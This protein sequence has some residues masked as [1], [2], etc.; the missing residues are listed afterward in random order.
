MLRMVFLCTILSQFLLNG[1]QIFP[2]NQ[3]ENLGRVRPLLKLADAH[4][5]L[6]VI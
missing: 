5:L 1:C 3:A 6:A 4:T 2:T